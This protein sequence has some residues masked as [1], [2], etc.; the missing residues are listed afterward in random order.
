MAGDESK[1]SWLKFTTLG[2]QMGTTIY[3][4]SLLGSYLDQ[5]YPT[6]KLSYHKV[7]TLIAVFGAMFSIIRQVLQMSKESDNKKTK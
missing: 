6:E 5:K 1:N 2:L 4:G 7:I 3:L